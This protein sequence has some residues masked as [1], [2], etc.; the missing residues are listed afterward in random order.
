MLMYVALHFGKQNMIDCDCGF[1]HI[2]LF[3]LVFES[4]DRPYMEL[5]LPGANG[6]GFIAMT[7]V[8]TVSF[9]EIGF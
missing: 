6:L 4:A 9:K 8:L 7:V 1:L 2:T 3:V 5:S